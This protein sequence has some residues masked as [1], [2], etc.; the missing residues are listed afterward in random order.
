MEAE[1]LRLRAAEPVETAAAESVEQL[2]QKVTLFR[3]AACT[4]CARVVCGHQ[5][6][7]AVA[8]GLERPHCIAC[9]AREM[10]Q[11]PDTLAGHLL[12][13][14]QRRSCYGELWRQQNVREGLPDVI[15][16]LPPC[17]GEHVHV[18]AEQ[19]VTEAAQESRDG[20]AV[21]PQ[22]TWDA[23]DLTCGELVFK[24]RQQMMN[25]PP[26]AVLCLIAR[27]PGAIEDIPAWCRL[28]GHRLVADR[29]PEYWIE[30]KD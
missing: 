8:L 13:H 3:D 10:A 19:A 23:G 22:V 27:D 15:Q 26:R 18:A 16:G 28:T 4:Q 17:L 12:A 25:L 24:L 6:L 9:L 14:F 5:A 7:F 1:H 30:R 21:E 20:V 2:E 29:H 11:P